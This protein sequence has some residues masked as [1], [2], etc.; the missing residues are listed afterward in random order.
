MIVYSPLT[1]FNTTCVNS[2]N[3]DILLE[4]SE[5]GDVAIKREK[6]KCSNLLFIIVVIAASKLSIK[7]LVNIIIL[8]VTLVQIH[9]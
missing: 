6:S 3:L 9:L 4:N 5:N 8:Y 1:G 7:Q 2:E